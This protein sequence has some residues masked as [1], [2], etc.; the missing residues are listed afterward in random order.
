MRNFF[1]K[2]RSKVYNC[3]EED[4]LVI[5]FSGKLK[6]KLGDEKYPFIPNRNMYY[7]TGINREN[8]IFVMS[9][10][11]LND[12][13]TLYI[14]RFDE[15]E[16][17]WTGAVMLPNECREISGIEEIKYIDEFYKDISNEIFNKRIKNIYLDLE[18][19]DFNENREAFNFSN[20]ITK[21]YPYININNIY[22]IIADF[23]MI[24]SNI[25]IEKIKKAIEITK[26]G[27]YEMMK[28]S[29]SGMMEYE[30]E[31]YFD[32]ILKK[33]GIKEKAFQSIAASGKNATVLHYSENNT[34]TK[35]GDL[36]LFDVGA[37]FEYY[38]GDITRTFPVSGKFSQ[39]QKQIY[40]IVL[41]G[42]LKVI[43]AVKPGIEFKSLN[44]ILVNYYFEEL[45]KIGLIKTKEDVSKYYYHG[46]SH[47]LGLETHDVGRYNEGI[48]K[49][50]MIFTVE[51]GLYIAEENIGIRI[52]DDVL[53]TDSGCEVLSKDII[54]SVDDI[55]KFM[56]EDKNE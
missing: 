43:N 48:L 44:E 16:A 29:K 56:S 40:N 1:D 22:N 31:S 12:R 53:V 42:Q 39:R 51:P 26:L 41:N 25:E 45:I 21:E 30:I 17:K 49:P 13:K 18:N 10:S 35:D 54:K 37:Q 27:I 28:N 4:S 38:N 5:L 8:I 34:K 7:L 52:E 19:R 24:K 46:V 9:K 23:R 11:K 3:I 55:E 47:M 32:F 36:I 50:G 6:I 2:N 33:N 20:K 15:F 14:E